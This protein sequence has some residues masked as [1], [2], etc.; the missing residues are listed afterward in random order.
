MLCAL[1]ARATALVALVI[2]SYGYAL[3]DPGA[4]IVKLD[5]RDGLRYTR[6]ISATLLRALPACVVMVLQGLGLD[7]TK[8]GDKKH[9]NQ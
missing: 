9:F 2:M 4:L 1:A 3:G 8:G 5:T 7:S 6:L